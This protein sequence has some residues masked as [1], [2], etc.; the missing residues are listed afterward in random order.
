MTPMRRANSWLSE[1][2]EDLRKQ[3]E[4]S[5]RAVQAYREK[6]DLV[7]ARGQTISAQQLSELNTQLVVARTTSL[8]RIA[9]AGYAGPRQNRQDR[10]RS[11]SAAVR[12]YPGSEAAG[13]NAGTPAG[14][15]DDALRRTAS[16]DHHDQGAA[17]GRSREDRAEV[18]QV[19]DSLESEVSV[20]R[21]R[22]ATMEQNLQSTK[23]SAESSNAGK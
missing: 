18:Q 8:G 15:V 23:A 9:P 7:Q 12:V 16:A 22:V 20:L 13:S 19:V 17:A 21:T 10:Q 11:R 2:L 4:E 5:D 3:A 1:R 6:A 14:R